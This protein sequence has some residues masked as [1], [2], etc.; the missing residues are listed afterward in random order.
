MVLQAGL[1]YRRLRFGRSI[2]VVS[3][4]PRSGTSMMM[5]MLEQ[6]GVAI[7][8]DGIRTPDESNPRGYYEFTPVKDLGQGRDVGWL[9]DAKGRAVKVVSSLLEHLPDR[10]NYRVIFMH[11]D[12]DEVIASQNTMLARRGETA[13]A[14]ADL[15]ETYEKH[16]RRVLG[17]VA[18]RPAFAL[19]AVQYTDALFHP[20][21]E[22]ARVAAFVGRPLDTSKMAA[23]VD[24]QLYR[25]RLGAIR[26]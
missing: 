19:L 11:R 16:I 21:D 10:C 1:L 13:G 25:N 18:R 4:L 14:S 12:L 26:P 7:L 15:R 3:G 5:R 9:A 8:S 23:A 22:A 17:M 6:G 2:I 20:I 24:A